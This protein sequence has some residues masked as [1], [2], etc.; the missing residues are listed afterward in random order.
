VSDERRVDVECVV[1]GVLQGSWNRSEVRVR[2]WM[3]E[4][5]LQPGRR[6]QLSRWTISA[7]SWAESVT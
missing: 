4:T 3:V 7:E 5:T 6:Y 1:V 2:S